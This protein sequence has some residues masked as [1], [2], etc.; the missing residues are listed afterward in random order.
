MSSNGERDEEDVAEA[1]V[2]DDEGLF[3]P[4]PPPAG[5]DSWSLFWG[6]LLTGFAGGALA[7]VAPW[8]GG[9]LIFGGYA[10]AASTLSAPGNRF[11]RAIR[12]GY[13]VSA[14]LGI[15]IV[16][17]HVLATPS[18][19]RIFNMLASRYLFFGAVVT[20]PLAVGMLR[21]IYA[22]TRQEKRCA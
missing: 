15:A 22:L 14:I 4:C 2:N 10:L 20:V 9:L 17:A 19:N 6:G 16:A 5:P 7:M 1:T 8:L 18:V 21:Y 11:V 13:I 3:L 12:F